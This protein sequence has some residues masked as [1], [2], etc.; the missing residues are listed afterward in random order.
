MDWTPVTEGLTTEKHLQH[1]SIG[2]NKSK[3]SKN[4]SNSKEANNGEV[5]NIFS[6]IVVSLGR[7]G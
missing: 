5:E 1:N 7:S 3:D 2:A 6:K 4:A